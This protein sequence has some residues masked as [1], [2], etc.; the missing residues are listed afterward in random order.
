ME[1][2]RRVGFV[3]IM[4]ALV[5]WLPGQAAA[6]QGSVTVDAHGGF[7]L[8]GGELSNFQDGGPS[9]GLDVRYWIT[10]RV[11]ALV[12]GS[13]AFQSGTDGEDLVPPTIGGSPP[14]L[15]A[16]DAPDLD[17]FNYFGGFAFKLT[18]PGTTP[19]NVEVDVGVGGTT[20]DADD[21][22]AAVPAEL[23]LDGD[24][25]L[26][27]LETDQFTNVS[28]HPGVKVG[29]QI[30]PRFNV[31][32]RGRGNFTFPDEEDTQAFAVLDDEI[33]TRGFEDLWT[34]PVSGGVSITF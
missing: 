17:I 16:V 25:E 18:P 28:I 31:F 23:D 6:Q 21:F 29:Y 22:P 10:D 8:P 13:L 34:V 4:A 32:V 26:E 1:T 19:W 30:N 5:A 2:L 15:P 9:A 11:A 12:G 27:T 3:A 14:F 7:S 20:V 33:D 24:G